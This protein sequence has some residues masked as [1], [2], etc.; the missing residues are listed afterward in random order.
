RVEDVT[1]LLRQV[2]GRT[3]TEMDREDVDSQAP[4][5]ELEPKGRNTNCYVMVAWGESG[6][7]WQEC[8]GKLPAVG[9]EIAMEEAGI[10]LVAT[11]I[12]QSPVPGDKRPWVY[13][14]PA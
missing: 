5:D 2:D 10:R 11:K 1:T 9:D 12:G 3:A 13:L 7:D 4:Y 14:Q 8:E 6:Y